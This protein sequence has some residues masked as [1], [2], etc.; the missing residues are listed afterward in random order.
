MR[1]ITVPLQ[2]AST[3][4]AGQ[5]SPESVRGRYERLRKIFSYI[6]NFES[7]TGNGGG[8][9]DVDELDDK[10]ESARTAGKDVGTLS[11]A[12][13]KKWYE[14]GWYDLFNER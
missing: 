1:L 13:L 8:D 11:G 10:I 12:I 2:V 4:F 6:L 7:M 3:V 9:P 14:Q 5:R